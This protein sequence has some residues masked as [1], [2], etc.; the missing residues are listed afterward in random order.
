[1]IFREATGDDYRRI[2]GMVIAQNVDYIDYQVVKNDIISGQCYVIEENGKVMSC[3]TLLWDY[4]YN[5]FY[6][7]RGFTSKMNQGK[8]YFSELLIQL[9]EFVNGELPIRV[10][11]YTANK[12]MIKILERIG[13]EFKK[14]FL[15]YYA[16]YEIEGL[17]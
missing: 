2:L 11:P 9:V 15:D 1:M 6:I 7:K 14:N 17:G 5:T 3:A 10:T 16:L 12:K 13:F 8:G 4:N